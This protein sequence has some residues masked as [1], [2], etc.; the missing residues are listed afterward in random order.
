M[1]IYIYLILCILLVLILILLYKYKNDFVYED[2]LSYK[3]CRKY[4]N[5]KILENTLKWS[6]IE[7][8]RTKEWDLYLPCTYTTV[9][10]ELKNL[11]IDNKNQMIFGIDGC[12]KLVAKDN[13]W[14]N[15]S[16]NYSRN[17]LKR[18]LPDTYILND[19]NDMRI[20]IKKYDKNKMYILKKNIQRKKGIEIS[21]NLSRILDAKNEGFVLVQ[22]YI[23]NLFLINKR[24]INL[25]IYLL[26]I[27]KKNKKKWYISKQGK[28]LYTNKDYDNKYLDK[29]TYLTSLNL[30][31]KIYNLNPLNLTDLKIYIGKKNYKKLFD[32]II[33]IC[34]IT[35]NIFMDKLCNNYNLKDN[36]K[37]QLFGL[38]FIFDFNFNPYLLEFNKGPEMSYINDNDKKIKEKVYKDIFN[39]VNISGE[40]TISN[41]EFIE[42]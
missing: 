21:N 6:D 38:D 13:L 10:K 16:N 18:F 31:K 5:N 4:K 41:N 11:D 25:R 20:F 22:N 33:N 8:T 1:E 26:I 7:K 2:F 42:I 37:F 3:K 32:R 24:K 36:T 40:N 28:C 23:N 27:C 34:K 35:K 12:D 15:F 17:Y 14:K 9:E 39:L 30:D 19:D 29:E